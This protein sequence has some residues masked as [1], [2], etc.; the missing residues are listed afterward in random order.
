MSRG[1]KR[2]LA[3]GFLAP[4]AFVAGVVYWIRRF[5]GQVPF[6]V[7]SAEEGEVV[8]R[9]VDPDQV[10]GL[11][12]QWKEGLEPVVSR[13]SRAAELAKAERDRLSG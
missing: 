9:L 13:L 11:W 7:W 10:P 2:G 5:T 1:F 12:Q 6:P 8:V 4:V 3:T